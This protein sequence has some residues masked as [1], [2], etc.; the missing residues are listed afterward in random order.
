MF[1]PA[2]SISKMGKKLSLYEY[3][4][5]TGPQNGRNIIIEAERDKG[6]VKDMELKQLVNED[7]KLENLRKQKVLEVEETA[8][9]HVDAIKALQTAK[10][11]VANAEVTLRNAQESLK[12]AQESERIAQEDVETKGKILSKD[13]NE[14]EAIKD[15][16]EKIQTERAVRIERMA[17]QH[18]RNINCLDDDKD[19]LVLLTQILGQF[20]PE[21]IA[22][23][24]RMALGRQPAEETTE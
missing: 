6:N 13:E 16:W 11:E 1:T 23:A 24:S 19:R 3:S 8:R 21:M 14:L 20:T 2:N 18:K 10:E 5:F 12:K 7:A 15:D 4:F 17:K 22:Q 9:E